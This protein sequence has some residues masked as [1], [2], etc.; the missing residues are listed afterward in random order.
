MRGK[1]DPQPWSKWWL[2]MREKIIGKN[3][4]KIR[5]NYKKQHGKNM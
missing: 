5:G 4:K 1:D 3:R 2:P